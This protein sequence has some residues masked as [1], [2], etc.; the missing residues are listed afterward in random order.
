[1][2]TDSKTFVTEWTAYA[3]LCGIFYI[4][5]AIMI[6]AFI[7]EPCLKVFQ[8]FLM[9]FSIAAGF[10]LWLARFKI[11]LTDDCIDY[12]GGFSRTKRIEFIK[13]QKWF[14]GW[15]N[16]N[17][18]GRKLPML[19]LIIQTDTEIVI[20]NIKPFSRKCI[21]LLNTTLTERCGESKKKQWSKIDPLSRRILNQVLSE[22]K[23]KVKK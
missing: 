1:M 2:N 13:V 4:L 20:M 11:V 14:F 6:Y 12:R 23:P 3:C 10:T 8:V 21:R 15:V 18:V 19:R 22:R 5:T 9:V 16:F 7:K 17:N